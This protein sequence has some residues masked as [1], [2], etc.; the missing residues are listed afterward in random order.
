MKR[1]LSSEQNN[2]FFLILLNLNLC[3]KQES[4]WSIMQHFMAF[5]TF[6]MKTNGFETILLQ[7]LSLVSVTQQLVVCSYASLQNKAASHVW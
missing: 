3:T 5:F 2:V 4:Y 7:L 1:I 6:Q